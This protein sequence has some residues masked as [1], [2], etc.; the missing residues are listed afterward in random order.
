MQVVAAA[1]GV[2]VW[3]RWQRNLRLRIFFESSSFHRC[4]GYRQ[5]KDTSLAKND[6]ARPAAA[7][8]IN[9]YP[10]QPEGL[11]ISY[12]PAAAVECGGKMRQKWKERN[13][14]HKSI[15][16][17]LRPSQDYGNSLGV[18]RLKEVSHIP[19]HTI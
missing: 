11:L 9:A 4:T 1:L 2:R 5:V 15:D 19:A 8:C 14:V 13:K 18:K 12:V 3:K 17:S 10:P 6:I 7:T 16:L